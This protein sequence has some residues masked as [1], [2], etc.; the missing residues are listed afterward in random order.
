LHQEQ[1]DIAMVALSGQRHSIR[2]A[3]NATF[4]ASAR[5]WERGMTK[6]AAET[7]LVLA[8]WRAMKAK[9]SRLQRMKIAATD[10]C[11]AFSVRPYWICAALLSGES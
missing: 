10:L 5:T 7:D 2:V 1:F 4:Y 8:K 11:S 3:R 6:P 9:V